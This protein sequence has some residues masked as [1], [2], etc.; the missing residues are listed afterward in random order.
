M[1]LS[2]I[3]PYN[4]LN[5]ALGL[6]R[7][8]LTDYVVAALGM[9]PGT[10]L[11]V[12]YGKA[13]GNVAAVVG[14]AEIEK[15]LASWVLLGVGLVATIIVTTLVTRLARRALVQEVSDD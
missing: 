4:L 11:Y 3:F 7:V 8:N 12:Y 15:G 13:L 14:G 9:I 6:T 1:R 5:Y 2:P 10:F